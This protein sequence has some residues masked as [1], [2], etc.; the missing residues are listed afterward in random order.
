MSSRFS[1]IV[2]ASSLLTQ[3]STSLF[4]GRNS[5]AP[6]HKAAA[7]N[8]HLSVKVLLGTPSNKELLTRDKQKM[9]PLLVA[10]T[11]GSTSSFQIL[12]NSGANF[13]AQSAHGLTAIQCAISHRH[14]SIV[15]L[16]SQD[17]LLVAFEEIFEYLKSSLEQK[18][19]SNSLKVLDHVVS[20]R[21][22]VDE[23]DTIP[24][25]RKVLECNGLSIIANILINSMNCKIAM[26]RV[27][28]VC[29]QIAEKLSRCD[30]LT[31]EIFTT[32]IPQSIVSVMQTNL[33][34]L[35]SAVE[36]LK[37]VEKP[38]LLKLDAPIAIMKIVLS[39]RN[40]HKREVAIEGLCFHKE[41]GQAYFELEFL[42]S[43]VQLLK[44][45]LISN[46]FLFLVL[47]LLEIIANAG[48]EIVK[49]VV[50]VGVTEILLEHFT[51]QSSMVTIKIISLLET[52]CASSQKAQTIVR[53]SN[54]TLQKLI[55]IS[56]FCLNQKVN[57]QTIKIIWLLA[58]DSD[59][60]KTGLASLLGPVC[61]LQVMSVGGT[62]LKRITITMLRL[63]SPDVYGLQS[64]IGM[65]GGVASLLK[66]VRLASGALQL[67]A[68]LALENLS[69]DIAMRIN[70][71]TQQS[72]LK[73]DGIQ[74]LLRLYL[75]A[76]DEKLKLQAFCT[77]A[78][79]S[80][81]NLTIKKTIIND[82][83]F[84]LK[85]LVDIFHTPQCDPTV[86][87]AAMSAISYLS[88][89]SIE[90][91]VS[92]C[93]ARRIPVEPFRKLL[94]GRD[95]F[96]STLAAFYLIVLVKVLEENEDKTAI[97]AECVRLLVSEL[98]L[99][100]HERI[101]SLQVSRLACHAGNCKYMYMYMYIHCYCMLIIVVDI[102]LNLYNYYF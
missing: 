47:N 18:E 85:E 77:L 95:R 51:N 30:L 1:L 79:V 42:Q 3:S 96:A 88:Y 72:V 76:S 65:A 56:K 17:L 41:M 25:Q 55:H 62:Q 64:E 102:A 44:E 97:V 86:M 11:Y 28:T 7:Q 19:L 8:N 38:V 69:H 36:I 73:M 37:R 80:I 74:L 92:I 83:K 81:G 35:V 39:S 48:E 67:E 2:P 94:W 70:K 27:G 61:I 26:Q 89:N 78:A 34:T 12:L 31:P 63:L 50:E 40:E 10:A 4:V 49:K 53:Q 13:S 66:I 33:E 71:V 43:I 57:F 15:L 59:K 60:E 100:V 75:T 101:I 21:L 9:T 23:V 5:F 90:T 58:G 93:E 20:V 68:L 14:S 54:P 45:P 52:L 32:S 84:S 87:R 24:L 22:C 6:I 82:P 16:L 29:I 98:E 91:Q 99:A 46:K